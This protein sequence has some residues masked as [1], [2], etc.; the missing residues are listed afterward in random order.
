MF[1]SQPRAQYPTNISTEF[2]GSPPHTTS[3]SKNAPLLSRLPG[4][5]PP[6]PPPPTYRTEHRHLVSNA[7]HG[8]GD[9]RFLHSSC[10]AAILHVRKSS[11]SAIPPPVTPKACRRSATSLPLHLPPSM[12]VQKSL[13]RVVTSSSPSCALAAANR[14]NQTWKVE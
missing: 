10:S 11:T 5:H 2:S 8:A 14:R 3:S 1:H 9:W 13:T 6:P 4:A 7:R 12:R